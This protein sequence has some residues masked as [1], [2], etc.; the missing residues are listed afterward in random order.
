[1]GDKT[2]QAYKYKGKPKTREQL[3]KRNLDLTRR[4]RHAR[5]HHEPQE[6]EDGR[7]AGEG[8]DLFSFF[9]NFLVITI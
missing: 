9:S 2:G 8:A 4:N 5:S 1:M 6:Q 3:G 7:Q